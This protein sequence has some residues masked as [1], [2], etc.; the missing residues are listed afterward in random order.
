M[1]RTHDRAAGVAD[2]GVEPAEPVDSL[3]DRRLDARAGADVELDVTAVH[4]AHDDAGSLLAEAVRDGGAD[5]GRAARDE[6]PLPLQSTA[7]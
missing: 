2:H 6:R 3:P 7:Q 4:V 5:T 1:H